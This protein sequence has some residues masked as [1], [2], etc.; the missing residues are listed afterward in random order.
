MDHTLLV[1]DRQGIGQRDREF[2]DAGNRKGAGRHLTIEALPLDQLHREEAGSRR[3]F[4]RVEHHDVRMVE[5]GDR[6][7]FAFEALQAVGRGSELGR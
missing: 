1:R 4:D 3:V 2:Q 6:S 7:R 5:R